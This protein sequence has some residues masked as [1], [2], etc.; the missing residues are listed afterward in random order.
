MTG[1]KEGAIAGVP[2]Q[3]VTT[4]P[5][6]IAVDQWGSVYVADSIGNKILKMSVGKAASTIVGTGK[7][8][9]AGD[10]G[11]ALSAELSGPGG[12]A[13]DAAGNLYVA[14]SGNN[15]VRKVDTAG[16]IRTFAGNGLPGDMGDGGPAT[17]ARLSAP[18]TLAFDGQGN[19]YIFDS[20]NNRVR[21]VAVDGII[22]TAALVP[23][24]MPEA[25]KLSMPASR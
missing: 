4:R 16:I 2:G 17:S 3:G 13:L 7:K 20:G 8:G 14:D 22:T 15:R 25:A 1:R 9:F 5:Q 6:N 23:T 10:G 21:R 19:L 12:V 18:T 24:A 11:P